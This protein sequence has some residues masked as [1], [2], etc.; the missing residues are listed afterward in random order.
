MRPTLDQFC[1]DVAQT[2]LLSPEEIQAALEPLPLERKPRDAQELIRELV[3]LRKLTVYQAQQIYQGQA[4]R[5]HLG[6]YLVLD[7]IGQGGMGM[8]LKAQHQRMRRV[9]A[10]KVIRPRSIDSPSALKR[11]HREVETAAQLIHPNIVTAYDADEADGTHFLVME[12]VDGTDLSTLVKLEGPL[13][14][15]TALTCIVQ[16][17]RGLEYA[18]A[19]GIIHRDIKP[20]NLLLG[21][22]G[23]LKILDM[24]LARVETSSGS[25]QTDLTG[26]GQI[27]GTVDYMAPEQAINPKNADQRADIY[28]LGITLWYL[29][30]GRLPYSGETVLEKLVAHREEP[31][32]SLAVARRGAPR[33]LEAAFERMVAK[34]PQHRFA[35][36]SELLAALDQCRVN[37]PGASVA[38]GQ[39]QEDHELQT[40]L[41]GISSAPTR[42]TSGGSS[43]GRAKPRSKPASSETVIDGVAADDTNHTF[44]AAG[45]SAPSPAAADDS[46]ATIAQPENRAAANPAGPPS[47]Q[48]ATPSVE[49]PAKS[50]AQ[51]LAQP[52]ANSS[53]SVQAEPKTVRP[54][55]VEAKPARQQPR[56]RHN[57]LTIS[58]AVYAV[59]IVVIILL[60]IVIAAF[61]RGG[62]AWQS[63]P[64]STAQMIPEC[65]AI[66]QRA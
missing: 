22:D 5:L 41:Q 61:S 47:F 33:E 12:Y 59:A 56:R 45:L 30:V 53:V 31:I 58:L 63:R 11:F 32:P 62:A 36:M 27:M 2:G 64:K 29:L 35:S 50:A 38:A 34:K 37:A 21:R 7:K 25:D 39:L 26:S 55:P 13:P 19:K 65:A 43:P 18:H 28:S 44:N 4:K 6:N 66:C 15:E 3:R 17:A 8:V 48:Q 46:S 20:R 51:P 52:A 54:A 14:I 23:K 49:P 40:F 9:V 42:R 60:L 57:S 24:G 10:L 16:A 1:S